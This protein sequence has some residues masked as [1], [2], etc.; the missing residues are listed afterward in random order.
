MRNTKLYLYEF[1]TTDFYV[2]DRDAG[3]FVSEKIQV[4]INQ[5]GCG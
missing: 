5:L 2:Q 3:Y 1:D 4:S